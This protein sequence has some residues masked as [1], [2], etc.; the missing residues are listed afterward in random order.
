MELHENKK[1]LEIKGNSRWSYQTSHRMHKNLYQLYL[2][3]GPNI[4][5]L[6]RIA[7]TK[8]QGNKTANQQVGK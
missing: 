7:G 2:G 5:N 4:Q 6:P 3:Q 8:Y 1:S